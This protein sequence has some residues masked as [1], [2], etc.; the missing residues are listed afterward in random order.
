MIASRGVFSLGLYSGTTS[1]SLNVAVFSAAAST[2]AASKPAECSKSPVVSWSFAVRV[3]AGAVTT[4]GSFS[5]SG[6]P[7]HSLLA[8]TFEVADATDACVEGAAACSASCSSIT[9]S[10]VS[11][12]AWRPPATRA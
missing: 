6:F 1:F 7:S 12:S 2:V 8:I 4:K 3:S 10:F 5:P 11:S 9:S